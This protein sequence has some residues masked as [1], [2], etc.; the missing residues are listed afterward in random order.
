MKQSIIAIIINAVRIIHK[1]NI[2]NNNLAIS[3][4]HL[5]EWKRLRIT[6]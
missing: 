3:T 4:A 6:P 5:M 1:L 2:Y